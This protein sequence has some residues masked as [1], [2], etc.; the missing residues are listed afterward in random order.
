[1]EETSERQPRNPFT[2]RLA[3]VG[4]GVM[5]EA[6][7]KAILRKGLVTPDQI[8]AS[9]PRP[10]R[11]ADLRERY[12]IVPETDN[13]AAVRESEI[14]VLS[15][16]PQ[17]LPK[18]LPGLRGHIKPSAVVVSIVAGAPTGLIQE[19]LGHRA[20]IRTMPNTPAQI[21]QGMTVW[22][23]TPEVTPQQ[24]E[25]VESLLLAMGEAVQVDDEVMLDMATAVSGTGPTYIFLMME[26]MTDA[27]VH[28]GFSR[29]VALK[30]VEQTVLG[31]VL[32][33]MQSGLH[34]AELRNQVTSPGGT[35]ADAIY[36]LEKGGLRTVL[37]KAI[38]AAYQKSRAL[39]QMQ[40]PPEA[41]ERQGGSTK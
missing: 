13:E 23:A 3:F 19:G 31:S 5:A 39:G 18:V 10:E 28:L 26:A 21:G 25:W 35:S 40:W 2:G 22:M 38:W 37:S 16:K 41:P 33:A 1:M 6:M 12:G 27:A 32:Y 8:V 4:S 14:V 11:G 29:R 24:R 20:V 9:G 17:V 36:Q 34:L 7:I 15:V 30:L